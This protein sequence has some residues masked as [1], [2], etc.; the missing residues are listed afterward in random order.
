MGNRNLDGSGNLNIN[1][2]NLPYLLDLL[3]KVEGKVNVLLQVNKTLSTNPRGTYPKPK[4]EVGKCLLTH[5]QNEH[6]RDKQN[7]E[8]LRSDEEKYFLEHIRQ[9]GDKRRCLL[10]L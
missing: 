9:L 8:E 7:Q 4:M 1:Q 6:K 5:Q 10:M 3:S 2:Q